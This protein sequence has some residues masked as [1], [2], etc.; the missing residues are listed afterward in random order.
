MNTVTEGSVAMNDSLTIAHLGYV[1]RAMAPAIRRFEDEGAR[2]LIDP[3][4]DPLQ[5]VEVCRLELE[6][7]VQVELVAP[8]DHPEC[9]VM[10]RLARGGGLDHICYSVESL[11][12]VLAREKERGAIVVCP[13]TYAVAFD[14]DVAFVHRRSGLVVEFMTR[15][16]TRD[17]NGGDSG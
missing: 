13:P 1:V 6:G 16:S 10:S 2:V 11:E 15:Q 17:G 12:P 3:V 9:P 7:G 5:H 8:T 4:L 14:R